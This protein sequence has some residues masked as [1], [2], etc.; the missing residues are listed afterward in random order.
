MAILSAGDSPVTDPCSAAKAARVGRKLAAAGA[1]KGG[2]ARQARRNDPLLR[3]CLVQWQRSISAPG[4]SEKRGR[5]VVFS[6]GY[7]V[8]IVLFWL[9]ATGWLVKEKI[10]PPLLVGDPPSYRTILAAEQNEPKETAWDIFLNGRRVGGAKTVTER[11]PDSINQLRCR[12]KLKELPLA[13]LTPAWITAVVKVMDSHHA[14][15]EAVIAVDSEATIDIDPLNRPVAF[16]SITKIGPPATD[17]SHRSL[18]SGVELNVTMR[19]RIEGDSMHVLMHSGEIDYKTEVDIPADALMGDV[20][21]PQTRLPGLRIGQTWTV[22]IYSPFRPPNAPVEILHATVERKDPIVWHDRIVPAL[23]VVYRG[24][25]GL[26]LSSNQSAR[27][28]MWV[29][30][31]GEVIKQ[32]MWLLSSRLL[33]VRSDPDRPL[34]ADFMPDMSRPLRAPPAGLEDIT[35]PDAPAEQVEAP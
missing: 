22:P 33:F 13:E 27:A 6:R 11:L 8:A 32:E 19:G 2:K 31:Q 34:E 26:G 5:K 1:H 28:Q 9:A 14:R 4:V 7:I 16:A 20:L 24:D 18:L 3:G 35:E 17:A 10:L 23:L 30:Y 25:P 29:D 15:G 21:S 12:V